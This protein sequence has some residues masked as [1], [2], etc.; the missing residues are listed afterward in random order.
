MNKSLGPFKCRCPRAGSTARWWYPLRAQLENARTLKKFVIIIIIDND[1]KG[2]GRGEE[3][4]KRRENEE[5]EVN[6]LIS[7]QKKYQNT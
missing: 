2:K 6:Y 7:N 5:R 4:E 3:K 1:E